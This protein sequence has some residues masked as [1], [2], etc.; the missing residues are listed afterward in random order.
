[1]SNSE[2]SYIFR[3]LLNQRR[4]KSNYCNDNL[5]NMEG[6]GTGHSNIGM[7]QRHK[8]PWPAEFRLA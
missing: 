5:V 6:E 3:I 1:L 7:K 2:N 8:P 4:N